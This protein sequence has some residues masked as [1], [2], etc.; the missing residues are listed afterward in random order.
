MW[1]QW[2]ATTTTW[3]CG[4]NSK[5]RDWEKRRKKATKASLRQKEEI[6]KGKMKSC[7][8]AVTVALENVPSIKEPGTVV[9]RSAGIEATLES[10][11]GGSLYILNTR[12][13]LGWGIDL[14]VGGAA[15]GAPHLD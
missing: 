11:S 4:H 12:D 13:H 9:P 3:L 14:I 1:L 5:D 15:S 10:S 6:A 2:E 8:E 7:L